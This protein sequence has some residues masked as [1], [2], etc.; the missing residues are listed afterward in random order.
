[1]WICLQSGFDINGCV[2][3][4]ARLSVNWSYRD[5]TKTIQSIQCEVLGTE[6]C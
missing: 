4:F 1:M 3:N 2:T 5:I 6:R